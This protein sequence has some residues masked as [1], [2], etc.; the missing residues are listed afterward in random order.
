MPPNNDDPRRDENRPEDNPFIAFRRFADS[1]ASSLLNTVFTL[2]ATIANFNNAHHAREQ[3]LFGRA[4]KGQCNKL[5]K[6]EEEMAKLRSEGRELY[7]VGDLQAVLEKGEELMQLDRQADALRKEIVE[8]AR[9]T[10]GE[11]ADS[12]KHAELVEKVGNEK[13]QQ[14]G[15]S[16]SWGF[17]RPFDEEDHS[18]EER[19][20]HRRVCR[21]WRR[22]NEEDA[23]Q[24]ED[25]W[26]QIH[27]KWEEI[28]KRMNEE[29]P[30]SEEG[31]P[32]VWRWS[33]NWPPPADAPSQTAPA[34]DRSVTIFD[35]L[36]DMIADE[37]NRMM[38]PRSFTFNERSYSPAALENSED[39]KGAGVQWRDAYEDLVRAE[40][41]APLIS[42]KE[43]GQSSNMSYSQWARRFWDPKFARPEGG[44]R[45]SGPVYPKRVPWEGEE[46]SEEP[47][48]EY[49]H[50]HEDQHDEPPSP[51]V[52][53]EKWSEG[54]PET[55]LDAYERLLGPVSAPAE[56]AKDGRS[57][58]LSTLTTTERTVAP[59]GTVTTK[60]VL[61]K[62]FADGREES[63]ETLH[64][65]RG[66]DADKQ[67]QDP[68]KAMQEA[69][70]PSAP[71]KDGEKKKGWFWSS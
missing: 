26:Q 54:M 67:Q 35:E 41:G 9:R 5:F 63:S 38:F 3:C 25:E 18:S 39:L 59:D 23:K 62:R 42:P 65:Q 12:R 19:S 2:P 68:W 13:G 45:H 10:T 17:P 15:W 70:F 52:E 6:L 33:F 4:H 36:T 31:E 7:R 37:V 61:K 49:S 66:Q 43:L 24:A 14:W 16:W 56:F 29:L 40:R 71:K 30:R 69:Q 22:R 60:V 53:Q 48:Y 55:E 50:D 1:Q 21:R 32:K 11:K 27:A 64:T 20:H 34:N 44:P 57:S 47:S 28:K 8:R 51:K 58:I 46:M